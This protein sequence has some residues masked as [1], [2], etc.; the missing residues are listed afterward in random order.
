MEKNEPSFDRAQA[1]WGQAFERNHNDEV[2]RVTTGTLE[3]A[4]QYLAQHADTLLPN[5]REFLE[6]SITLKKEHASNAQKDEERI[7]TL[8][9]E[10]EEIR[11]P[12][13]E[14][15]TETREEKEVRFER[16][17]QEG[18][19]LLAL[20]DRS[21]GAWFKNIFSKKPVFT[22]TGKVYTKENH[23]LFLVENQKGEKFA[24]Y[25]IYNGTGD[26]G[27]NGF[28]RSAYLPY[29]KVESFLRT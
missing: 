25:D 28:V 23:E 6:A 18:W 12:E 21:I 15:E 13:L 17:Y 4:E 3:E 22:E 16:M 8:E 2:L 20:E 10:I 5:E 1:H 9:A 14:P 27:H 24:R 11:I 19:A 29:E 26:P 7:E